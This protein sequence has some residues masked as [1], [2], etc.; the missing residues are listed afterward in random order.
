[1]LICNVAWMKHYQGI[2]ETDYPVNG[3]EYIK[4]NGYGHEVINF[5]RN[6]QFVYGYVQAKN[7][8]INIDRIGGAGQDY[9]DNVLVVWRARSIAGAV[10]IGWYKNARVYRNEQPG[11]SRRAFSYQDKVHHPGYLIRAKANDSFLIPPQNRIFPVPVTHK[12]FGSQTFVS[13]LEKETTEVNDYKRKL[14]DFIE[15]AENGNYSSP[16]KGR[17]GHIDTETKSKIEKIAIDTTVEFYI[18]RGYDVATVERDNVGYDLLVSKGAQALHVEVKGTSVG[19]ESD[20]NVLLTP[21]EYKV[22]KRSKSL[23][24]ICIVLNTLSTPEL[25]E[26]CWD[27]EMECWFSEQSLSSL[28]IAE[29]ISAYLRINNG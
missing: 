1:M 3:G 18:D 23:Y 26:F 11:N 22:S 13:F 6:G 14:I 24:R 27:K 28:V 10:V 12:G 7:A 25:Y 20:V 21:N 17:R 4:K 9:V 2:T 16:I 8:T 29:S 5:A 15:R 19:T